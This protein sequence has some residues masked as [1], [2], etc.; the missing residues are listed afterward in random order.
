MQTLFKSS[1]TLLYYKQQTQNSTDE[2]LW[3]WCIIDV[4]N[5]IKNWFTIEVISDVKVSLCEENICWMTT[6]WVCFD[7][8]TEFVSAVH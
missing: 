8:K 7:E 5:M 1:I 6:E 3:K 4:E 2:I